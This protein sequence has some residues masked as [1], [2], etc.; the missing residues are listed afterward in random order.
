MTLIIIRLKIMI[1][2]AICSLISLIAAAVVVTLRP[3]PV[4]VRKGR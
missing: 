2:T 4:P 1:T 3:V